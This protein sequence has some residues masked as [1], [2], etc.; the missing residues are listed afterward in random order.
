MSQAIMPKFGS[1]GNVERLWTDDE[2]EEAML[3][4]A[5]RERRWDVIIELVN[6][7]SE[8]RL[9]WHDPMCDLEGEGE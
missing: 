7:H 1:S 5:W 2:L 9:L 8:L 4:A 3:I 6:A